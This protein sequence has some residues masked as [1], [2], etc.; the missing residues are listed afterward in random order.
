[1]VT[2]FFGGVS[3]VEV[4]EDVGAASNSAPHA[5]SQVLDLLLDVRSVRADPSQISTSPASNS[6]NEHILRNSTTAATSGWS[7]LLVLAVIGC[8]IWRLQRRQKI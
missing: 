4:T 8:L 1:L 5:R 6:R 7:S 2:D 3:K